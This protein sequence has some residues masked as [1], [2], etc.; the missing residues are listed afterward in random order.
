LQLDFLSQ[1][2]PEVLPAAVKSEDDISIQPQETKVA[3]DSSYSML[4]H[5]VSFPLQEDEGTKPSF[6][7]PDLNLPVEGDSGSGV[8]S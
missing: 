6:L 8:L 1:Q 2:R 3:C 5:N 4:P 7:L